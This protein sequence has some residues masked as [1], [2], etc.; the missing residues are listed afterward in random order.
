MMEAFHSADSVFSVRFLSGT[1]QNILEF[2]MDEKNLQQMVSTFRYLSDAV[3]E[4][5]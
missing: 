4:Q 2:L 5:L 3:D 1:L